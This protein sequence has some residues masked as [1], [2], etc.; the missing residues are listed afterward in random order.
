ML[1]SITLQID[2]ERLTYCD[3]DLIVLDDVD[4]PEEIVFDCQVISKGDRIDPT[5]KQGVK[6]IWTSKIPCTRYAN[7]IVKASVTR[8]INR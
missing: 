4:W 8:Q 6:K 5:V 3:F 2:K 7:S 1:T